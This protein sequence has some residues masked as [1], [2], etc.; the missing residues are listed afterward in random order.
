VLIDGFMNCVGTFYHGEFE[1]QAKVVN[2]NFNNYKMK[3][4]DFGRA[5][6]LRGCQQNDEKFEP[7]IFLILITL[8][9]I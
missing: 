6:A 3:S 8:M 7:G 5:I 2:D 4:G 9:I 1:I